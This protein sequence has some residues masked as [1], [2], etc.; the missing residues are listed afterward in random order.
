MLPT[1]GI[2]PPPPASSRICGGQGRAGTEE[3]VSTNQATGLHR[4]ET[5]S[6]GGVAVSL[7]CALSLSTSVFSV[8]FSRARAS[9]RALD[10]A[11]CFAMLADSW[12]MTSSCAERE[13][14]TT[15]RR[16][17]RHQGMTRH[18]AR[19]SCRDF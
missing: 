17:P 6:P 5:G 8:T 15:T 13:G 19:W 12:R 11:S 14:G 10:S 7:A 18:R 3:G 4:L 2:P 9:H 16:R 1:L